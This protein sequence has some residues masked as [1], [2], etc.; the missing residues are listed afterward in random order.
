M[1]I[2]RMCYIQDLKQLFNRKKGMQIKKKKQSP[3]LLI[4][5]LKLRIP[6]PQFA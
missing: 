3:A 5:I 6:Q 1:E 2:G 4:A